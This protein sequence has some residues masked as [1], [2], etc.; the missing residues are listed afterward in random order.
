MIYNIDGYCFWF[1][2]WTYQTLCLTQIDGDYFY[3]NEIK[4]SL[5]NP[6]K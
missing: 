3:N 1:K 4:K 5:T 2:V 6:E